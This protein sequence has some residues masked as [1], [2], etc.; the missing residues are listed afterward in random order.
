MSMPKRAARGD[1]MRW[2]ETVV[3]PGL[4]A[5]VRKGDEADGR[6]P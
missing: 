6:A 5:Q 3:Q 2:G 4:A 1:H